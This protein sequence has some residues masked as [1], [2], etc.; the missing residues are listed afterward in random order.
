MLWRE[1]VTVFRFERRWL[2][3]AIALGLGAG[4]AA[5]PLVAAIVEFVEDGLRS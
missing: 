4:A 1:I 5:G 2:V 3:A